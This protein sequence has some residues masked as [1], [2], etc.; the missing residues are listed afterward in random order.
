MQCWGHRIQFGF[1][2]PTGG[3]LAEPD[4]LTRLA[5]E[6]E[7]MGFDYLTFSDHIVIPTDIQARYPYS[8]PAS[9]RKA[10]AAAGTNN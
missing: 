7:A 6:A 1:N 4:T 3:P 10:P 5:V 9:S 2:A 8:E